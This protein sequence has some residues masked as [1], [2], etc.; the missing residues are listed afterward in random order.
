LGTRL[1]LQRSFY[2]PA[3]IC[4]SAKLPQFTLCLKTMMMYSAHLIAATI[5]QLRTLITS[6][7]LFNCALLFVEFAGTGILVFAD[8]NRSP[9]AFSQRQNIVNEKS[10]CDLY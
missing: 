1:K 9:P 5:S 2:Q 6:L 4:T 10:G 3:P 8:D 7:N